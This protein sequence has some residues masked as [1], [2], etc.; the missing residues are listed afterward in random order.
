MLFAGLNSWTVYS[1]NLSAA[2]CVSFQFGS[3]SSGN[4]TGSPLTHTMRRAVTEIPAFALC[5]PATD[6]NQKT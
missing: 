3:S 6:F 4:T 1:L 2:S 5:K